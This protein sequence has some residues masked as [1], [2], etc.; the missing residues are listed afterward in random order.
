MKICLALKTVFI[1]I[2]GILTIATDANAQASRTWV[3]AEG[4][5]SNPCSLTSPCQTFSAAEVHTIVGGE[6]GALDPGNF[7]SLTIN[8]SVIIDCTGVFASIVVSTA[9]NGI[10]VSAGPNDVVILRNLTIDGLGQGTDG[11]LFSTGQTLIIENCKIFGW[12]NGIHMTG[13][14]NL[15][16][17]NTTFENNSS[18]G[19]LI[20]S[21]AGNSASASLC[22]LAL[23]DNGNG[24]N[25]SAGIV[26]ICNSLITQNPGV[27]IWGQGS[28]T[29]L[30][31]V[32]NLLTSNGTAIQA[33][34]DASI[35]ISNND[36]YN[37]GIALNNSGTIA[38]A[39]NNR[40][41]GHGASVGA[42]T[43]SINI[44]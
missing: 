34:S 17:R 31:C 28:G 29:I 15:V 22:S 10:E 9:S 19:V 30:T 13:G 27:A 38:T 39:N 7:Q 36:I 40:E 14:S 5:D 37:N 33:A 11:I 26:S 43:T 41:G 6:I 20:D 2:L 18:N 21:S 44:Q 32:N 4:L 24:I 25:A 12:Q 42:P 16:V 35:R 8:Q 23:K 1:V 3:S